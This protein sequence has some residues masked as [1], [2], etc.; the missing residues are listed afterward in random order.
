MNILLIPVDLSGSSVLACRIGFA[1]ALRLHLRPVILHGYISSY[2]MMPQTAPIPDVDIV[3]DDMAEYDSVRD[4]KLLLRQA[5]LRFNKFCLDIKSAQQSG[6][7]VDVDFGRELMAGVPEDLIRQFVRDHDTKLIVMATRGASRR[8][9]ELI[10]SITVEVID[11]CRVPVFTVPENMKFDSIAAIRRLVFFCNMDKNDLKSIDSLMLMFG[12]PEIELHLVPVND[13]DSSNISDRLDVMCSYLDD[14][15]PQSK[16]FKS[17]IDASD[18]RIGLENYL[19]SNDIQ[20]LVVP[21]KKQSVLKRLFNPGIA[22]R[23]LF[24]K[25]LPMLA[26]PI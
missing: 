9:E 2:M 20:M 22:H 7:I 3:D 8:R 26:L 13:R 5:S 17:M 25:D 12:R 4:A 10:G 6:D 11:S 18:F 1:L 24:E 16:F 15:Y 23:I 21:N 14:K 19:K